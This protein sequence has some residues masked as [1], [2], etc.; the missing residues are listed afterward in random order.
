M[1][2]RA[3]AKTEAELQLA[4]RDRRAPFC[5]PSCAEEGWSNC[6]ERCFTLAHPTSPRLLNSCAPDK[7]VNGHQSDRRTDRAG[8]GAAESQWRGNT[9]AHQLCS[10]RASSDPLISAW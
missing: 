2:E 6:P 8:G 1:A 4:K 10:L 7:K 3:G 5:T 9:A